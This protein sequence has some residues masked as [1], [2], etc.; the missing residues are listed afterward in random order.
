MGKIALIE[1][2]PSNYDWEALLPFEFE[3]LYLVE[4]K[5]EKVLVRDLTLNVKQ[6][7]EEY[8]KLILVGKESAKMVGNISS[9]TEYQGYLVEDKFI[10]LLN[11]Y[12]VRMKPSLKESFEKSINDTINIIT[13]N[14]LVSSKVECI[15]LQNEK[16]IEDYL[17]NIQKLVGVGSVTRIAL[18]TETTGLYSRDCSV[19]G[20]SITYKDKSGAYLDSDFISEKSISILQ[21]IINRTTV[22]FANAKFDLHMLEYHFGLKFGKI[23]DVMLLHYT[24]DEQVGTHGLKQLA[25]KYTDLGDYDRELESFKKNYCKT[26]GI[27]VG[28]FTYDL[29][30]F[31]ILNVYAAIDTIATYELFNIFYDKVY[32]N[33]KLKL[34]YERL[35]LQGTRFLKVV[36]DNGIPID[37][38]R[39]YKYID[40][41]NKEVEELTESLYNYQEIHDIEKH[42]GK[43]FNTNSVAHK[44]RLFFDALKLPS[45]KLTEKGNRSTDAEVIEGLADLHPL[46]NIIN[47]ISKLKKV[48]STYLEKFKL[49][50]RDGRLR[51]NFS[52]H[53]TTSG[54]LS[55]SGKINAQQLPRKDKRPKKC[56]R[57]KEG[58]KIVSQD[59]KTAEM[60]VAAVLSGD[61]NLQNV[62]VT[63]E[64]YHGAMA[65][66]KFGLPCSANEVARLYPDLRQEAKT[67]SFEILYKLNYNEPALERFPKLKK[68]L[69]DQEAF[70]KKNGY[71]YSHF[72]RK[73]RLPDVFS[74]NRQ[75]AQHE[76]RSGIN[77][78][79]QSVS[80]DI[81]LLAGIDMQ[82]WIEENRYS[83]D[84]KIFMLVHDSIV[85]EVREDL[86]PL[87]VEKLAFFTQKIRAGLTIPGTP[88]G[89]DLDI[90]DDY[91][92]EEA[93]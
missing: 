71:I 6:V 66:F 54:R 36:E 82:N 1:K 67:I 63:G 87:Y 56:I 24:L 72:G 38:D 86:I 10:P 29:I 83:K 31:S 37:I 76:V 48:K 3:K 65:K 79:V 42:Y 92:M 58:F 28:E 78:L 32:N 47:S 88:V 85:A 90:G 18:D 73:R 22:L 59:L 5:M 2:Y 8:E 40:E 62:F 77:F 15:G 84:M 68:W 46:P 70:I 75:A 51:T 91:S 93:A 21:D 16:Q 64:D 20:I 34:M 50:N 52:L 26:Y 19:L 23:H 69:K 43:K 89:L 11:P 25:I 61:K 12:A 44:A 55:S 53:T 39:V 30:P 41:I 74:P 45:S 49:L 33:P 13:G 7:K 81:N 60:Y 4:E 57:A 35:L 27:K 17:L 9:V 14:Q 80:S